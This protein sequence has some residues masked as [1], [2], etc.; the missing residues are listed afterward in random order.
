MTADLREIAGKTVSSHLERQM[1]DD[2]M[3]NLSHLSPHGALLHTRGYVPSEIRPFYA[4]S[5]VLN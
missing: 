2:E 5:Q 1:N 4:V 3:L